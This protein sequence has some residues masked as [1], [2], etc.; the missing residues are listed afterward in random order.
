MNEVLFSEKGT[1]NTDEFASECTLFCSRVSLNHLYGP[2]SLEKWLPPEEEDTQVASQKEEEEELFP[3][4]ALYAVLHRPK[5]QQQ[6]RRRQQPFG[7][8]CQRQRVPPQQR[9]RNQCSWCGWSCYWSSICLEACWA[10]RNARVSWGL[11]QISAVTK[12][13]NYLGGPGEEPAVS[14]SCQTDSTT[15]A[16]SNRG[17]VCDR[18]HTCTCASAWL[19]QRLHWDGRELLGKCRTNCTT[20]NVVATEV[21]ATI[22]LCQP[23]FILASKFTNN[24]P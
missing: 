21:T 16:V 18:T 19:H 24:K 8:R 11:L 2:S 20:V 5:Q 22:Y 15:S 7:G 10:I 23:W 12:G 13:T 17:G 3:A 9:H 14:C 6:S 4:G 1:E